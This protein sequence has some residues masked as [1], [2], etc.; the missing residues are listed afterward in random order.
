MSTKRFISN[1]SYDLE[2]L[3]SWLNNLVKNSPNS[4]VSVVALTSVKQA[5]AGVKP[6]HFLLVQIEG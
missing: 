3:T 2:E 1:E 4:V 6:K 5:D